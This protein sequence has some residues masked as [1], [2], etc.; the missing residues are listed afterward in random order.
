MKFE[1]PS[2]KTYSIAELMEKIEA[3]ACSPVCSGGCFIRIG[4]K[5]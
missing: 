5:G 1:K 3:G 4:G 2:M